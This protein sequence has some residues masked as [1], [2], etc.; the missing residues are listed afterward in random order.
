MENYDFTDLGMSPAN[1]LANPVEDVTFV[2]DRYTGT[3]L[4][5]YKTMYDQQ[6][7]E[8]SERYL[9]AHSWMQEEESEYRGNIVHGKA[10]YR[11]HLKDFGAVDAEAQKQHVEEQRHRDDS[12]KEREHNTRLSRIQKYYDDVKAGKFIEDRRMLV[13]MEDENIV[14]HKAWAKEHPPLIPA[15]T[16]EYWV[17]TL[18]SYGKDLLNN[19][20]IELV[21]MALLAD[22]GVRVEGAGYFEMIQNMFP[23]EVVD[24]Q[25]VI[26]FYLDTLAGIYMW[27]N[28]GQPL[29]H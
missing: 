4:T 23:G 13:N 8:H 7:E 24:P 6:Q 3:D 27:R 25:I 29:I 15:E 12:K 14:A 11:T 19:P 17:N 5:D 26:K 1:A 22:L 16:V 10:Y 28:N 21:T 9:F 18:H 2:G 20:G